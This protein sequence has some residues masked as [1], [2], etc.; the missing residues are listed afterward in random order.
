MARRGDVDYVG[1]EDY[2]TL[3]FG[4]PETLRQLTSSG[5]PELMS[6]AA[7]LAEH[8][9]TWEQLVDVGILCG[10]DFNDGVDGVGPKT[11]LKAV[12]EY[13]DLWGVLE[14]RGTHV[15]NADRVRSLFLD[16]PVTDDYEFDTEV[17]PDVDAARAYVT[18]EWEVDPDAVARGF[19]RIEEATTQTGLD[20]WT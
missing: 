18:E 17:T 4:A 20:R 10:T 9:L 19:G 5:D 16:P 6:L 2:D 3:L 14:A 1:S 15:P 13:G 7:T 8:D 11:A 12:H